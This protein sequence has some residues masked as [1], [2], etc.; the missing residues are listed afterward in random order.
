M[1]QLLVSTR[2]LSQLCGS[3]MSKPYITIGVLT[4]AERE[5]GI[6]VNFRGFEFARIFYRAYSINIGKNSENNEE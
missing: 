1:V 4:V 2:Y 3:H 5:P 6:L